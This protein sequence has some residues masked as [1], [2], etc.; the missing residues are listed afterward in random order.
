MLVTKA[1]RLEEQE[2]V[3]EDLPQAQEKYW[4]TMFD[5]SNEDWLYIKMKTPA[6]AVRFRH[7]SSRRRSYPL[8]AWRVPAEKPFVAADA[9]PRPEL[10]EA[11]AACWFR[12]VKLTV[13]QDVEETHAF[14]NAE[15]TPPSA[16]AEA[17]TLSV[18]QTPTLALLILLVRERDPCRELQ[19]HPRQRRQDSGQALPSESG[20][21][22]SSWCCRQLA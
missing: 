4:T 3:E 11:L 12:G 22:C 21:H 14:V 20:P 13:L 16:D 15:P 18:L 19:V 9:L 8:K 6:A 17:G 7:S 1:V 5:L 2:E 10:I